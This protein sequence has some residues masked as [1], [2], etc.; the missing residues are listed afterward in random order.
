MIYVPNETLNTLTVISG[1]S[2][3][4]VANVPLGGV[5]FAAAVN[6][7]TNLVYVTIPD[8]SVVV[9]DG[10]TNTV[11]ATIPATTPYSIAV[12]PLTNLIYFISSS[13]AT[14]AVGVIDGASNRVVGT[15]SL[16]TSCCVVGI[17]VNT[18]TNRI[19]VAEDL[20][21][22]QMVVI[23]G[24]NNKFSTFAVPGVCHF[25]YIATDST[26][27]RTYVADDVCAELY[28]IDDATDKV[29]MTVLPGYG[30]PIAANGVNH[31]VADF[32][33]NV[34]SFISGRTGALLGSAVN[35]PVSVQ[36]VDVA[37][38]NNNRYYVSLYSA[39]GSGVG[40]VAGPTR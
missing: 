39:S 23:N 36:A 29:I 17:A 16:S 13:S 34:L 30:G 38:G 33:L 5:P 2:R 24:A 28:M 9:V 10:S 26:L 1:S 25:G 22:K 31:Q 27:G 18:V 6:P 37:A 35:F 11:T 40:V 21:S 4:V 8:S 14:G 15:I 7:A 3:Q 32:S 20:S 12:N 19:Y